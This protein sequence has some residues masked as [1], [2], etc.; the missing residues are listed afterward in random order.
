MSYSQTI[1]RCAMKIALR[2]KRKGGF[3]R[4]VSD[5]S[6]DQKD[7]SMEKKNNLLKYI[8]YI[9]HYM[10]QPLLQRAIHQYY[11]VGR[12]KLARTWKNYNDFLQHS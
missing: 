7:G 10:C 8:P 5:A 2:V 11:P 6:I 12:L 1:H 9:Y 4:S 3:Y